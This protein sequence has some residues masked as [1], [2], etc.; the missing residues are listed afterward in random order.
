[1]VIIFIISNNLEDRCIKISLQLSNK[2]KKMLNWESLIK[3]KYNQKSLN[4]KKKKWHFKKMSKSLTNIKNNTLKVN[5]I[6]MTSNSNTTRAIKVVDIIKTI[7]VTEAETLKEVVILNNIKEEAIIEVITIE[8]EEVP[9][10]AGIEQEIVIN[11]KKNIS[12][13]HHSTSLNS[14]SQSKN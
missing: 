5:M 9:E 11:T 2:K 6:S 4:L 12:L 14:I 7:L 10:V 13:L 3:V 8:A 1:M